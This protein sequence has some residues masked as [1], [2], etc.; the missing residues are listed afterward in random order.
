MV[1]LLGML[2]VGLGGSATASSGEASENPLDKKLPTST[3]NREAVAA[4]QSVSTEPTLYVDGLRAGNA[5]RVGDQVYM[6]VRAF[7][8][9]VNEYTG[10]YAEVSW[11]AES[12]TVWL[13]AE[14][15]SASATAGDVFMQCNGRYFYVPQGMVN[16]GGTNYLPLEEMAKCF[17]LSVSWDEENN[18]VNVDTAGAAP[19][20][21]ADSYY[22]WESLYWM[23]RCINAEAGDQSMRGQLAVGNVIMNR[24]ASGRFAQTSVKSVIFAE[25]QFDVVALGMIYATPDADAVIAAKMALEGYNVVPEAL[26]FATFSF[27]GG[28]RVVEWIGAHCFM[29]R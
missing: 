1:C 23:S 22:D 7:A 16:S 28:Y 29:T 3:A 9:L 18:V 15:V 5:T 24:V 12:D 2:A 14:G 13:T 11:D 8:E 25:G 6:G 20:A 10:M 17:G 26:F 27:G 21:D 4:E 19:A